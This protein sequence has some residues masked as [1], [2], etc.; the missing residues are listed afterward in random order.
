MRRFLAITAV[1]VCG[2]AAWA[3]PSDAS[4]GPR[5]TLAVRVQ[6]DAG[7]PPGVRSHPR[8]KLLLVVKTRWGLTVVRAERYV[9]PGHVFSYSLP[10]GRY[11]IAAMELPP[12]VNPNP[13]PCGSVPPAVRVRTRR[14]V[15]ASVTCILRG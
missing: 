6:V 9:S 3:L 5:G 12:T 10:T 11:R 8:I 7:G 1:L 13:L 2:V 15:E 4:Q 14:R